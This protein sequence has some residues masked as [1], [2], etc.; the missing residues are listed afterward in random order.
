MSDEAFASLRMALEDALAF[1]RGTR[2]E[3]VV[4]RIEKPR[5]PKAGSPKEPLAKRRS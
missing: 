5:P 1:E 4:T 3:L 2:R